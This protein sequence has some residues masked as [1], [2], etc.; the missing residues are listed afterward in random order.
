MPDYFCLS[1]VFTL[2][3]CCVIVH[4]LQGEKELHACVFPSSLSLGHT[5]I[6]HSNLFCKVLLSSVWALL[7]MY[8]NG[9]C[10]RHGQRFVIC[11]MGRSAA[12][13]CCQ[14]DLPLRGRKPITPVPF[15]PLQLP[16]N[17]VLTSYSKS[18]SWTDKSNSL[19]QSRWNP[20][21][22]DSSGDKSPADLYHASQQFTWTKPTTGSACLSVEHPEALLP[23]QLRP[24]GISH[25]WARDVAACCP[26]QNTLCTSEL[27]SQQLECWGK[28]CQ[29][30]PT[31]S[32][33]EG[34]ETPELP[35][36]ACWAAQLVPQCLSLRV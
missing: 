21:I 22:K 6:F 2:L 28:C 26:R 12:G 5:L 13:M 20:A 18:R 36:P 15:P 29:G 32:A 17:C 25:P 34:G 14:S 24:L 19:E 16:Q 35:L 30:H 31:P 4:L 7:W 11:F 33:S 1:S 9:V 10:L 8:N 23:G 27:C 3:P